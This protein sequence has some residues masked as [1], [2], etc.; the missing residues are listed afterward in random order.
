MNPTP[1]NPAV[2]PRILRDRRKA[3]VAQT[4]GAFG[5]L[6]AS[7]TGTREDGYTLRLTFIEDLSK[8]PQGSIPSGITDEALSVT[9]VDAPETG[10]FSVR[11]I[12]Q[13]ETRQTLIVELTPTHQDPLIE[14]GGLYRVALHGVTGVD[15]HFAWVEFSIGVRRHAAGPAIAHTNA[16]SVSQNPRPSS[17][18]S[19]DG[20]GFRQLMLERMRSTIPQWQE[21]NP[22]DLGVTLV[23][24]IA[25]AADLLSYYQD[26][27]GTEAYT[28]TARQRVSLRRHGRLIGVS[29]S[30]GTGARTWLA[31]EVDAPVRIAAGTRAGTQPLSQNEADPSSR[32]DI[33]FETIHPVT[34]HPEQ[35]RMV[36]HCWGIAP[37]IVEAGSTTLTL[38]GHLQSLAEGSV[39]FILGDRPG[40]DAR[41]RHAVRLTRA[42][43]MTRDQTTGTDITQ[44]QWSRTDALPFDLHVHDG[45]DERNAAV[46]LGNGV[47]AK[48]GQRLCIQPSNIHIRDSSIH[49]RLSGMGSLCY[50]R[51][52]AA[53]PA[54]DQRSVN[55]ANATHDI[56]VH[57]TR[58]DGRTLVWT[59]VKDLLGSSPID[60]HFV[61]EL[62][63]SMD[64]L[65]RFG[66]GRCGLPR[67]P[68]EQI[69]VFVNVGHGQQGNVGPDALQ[70]LHT[71][72]TGL[73]SV[74]NPIPATGGTRPDTLEEARAR[75]MRPHRSAHA[76]VEPGDYAELATQHPHVRQATAQR[77]WA[78]TWP[79]MTVH[80]LS[81][82]SDAPSD[83]VLHEVRAELDI[84]RRIGVQVDVRPAAMVHVDIALKVVV[85]TTV[86]TP[87][88]RRRILEALGAAPSPSK[89]L[90]HPSN[91]GMGQ[92]VYEAPLIR[93]LSEIQGI[94]W[95]E[96][97]RFT[98]RDAPEG[99]PVSGVIAVESHEVVRIDG[100]SI[101]INMEV[102]R[103]S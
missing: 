26:A 5:L 85:D 54:S 48:Q 81:E 103:G 3:L 101:A 13:A 58:P 41:V 9:C 35:N 16:P 28:D 55:A 24:S 96:T 21:R 72:H 65:L 62:N 23:E 89:G 30:D 1:P 77:S 74:R 42:P 50:D 49:V 78:G 52:D 36:P 87:T 51:E 98:R 15:P 31:F 59:S 71:V 43:V 79:C 6:R 37:L 95:L 18:L 46:V 84:H 67:P 97:L 11:A 29:P 47:L 45:Q 12:T 32:S 4:E 56:E 40:S 91:W 63:N 14:H 76:C 8:S 69:A 80:L 61:A 102:R 70:Y 7:M 57:Q 86:P 92:P 20:E 27:V 64:L 68:S 60:R 88:V 10:S 93:R 53:L 17:Y 99:A 22:A 66:D 82:A 19:R 90:F 44:I 73:R 2:D 39:L 25:H 100:R 75:V 83:Q 38:K 34:A 33:V 94:Q